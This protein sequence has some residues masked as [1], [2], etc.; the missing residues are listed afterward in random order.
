MLGK[1]EGFCMTGINGGEFA[2]VDAWGIA[3]AREYPD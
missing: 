1:E 3:D 2:R